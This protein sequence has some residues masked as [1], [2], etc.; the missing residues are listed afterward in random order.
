M[1]LDDYMKKHPLT[2]QAENATG[3]SYSELC[4]VKLELVSD[5]WVLT[6]P[7]GLI[8]PEHCTSVEPFA[9]LR[10]SMSSDADNHPDIK[11]R[12]SDY[13]LSESR[14]V[15]AGQHLRKAKK[16][17]E[18]NATRRKGKK[19][20]VTKIIER[21]ARKPG[22][23]ADLWSDFYGELDA[24]NMEPKEEVINGGLAYTYRPNEEK[25][26]RKQITH[27]AFSNSLTIAREKS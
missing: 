27:K 10:W 11:D 24:H 22:K 8:D 3:L 2:I 25:D 4:G 12:A 14:G 16:T 23:P 1:S 26:E 6:W 7:T 21:I 17:S 13:L 9:V 15:L 20:P 18:S 5:G 19:A